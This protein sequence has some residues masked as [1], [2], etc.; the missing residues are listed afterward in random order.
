MQEWV[1]RPH[2]WHIA[3]LSWYWWRMTRVISISGICHQ[4]PPVSPTSPG[5]LLPTALITS[6]SLH[7]QVRSWWCGSDQNQD[8]GGRV[9]WGWGVEAR[10]QDDIKTKRDGWWWW[11]LVINTDRRSSDPGLAGP[12]RELVTLSSKANTTSLFLNIDHW[13][14]LSRLQFFTA[15]V[16]LLTGAANFLCNFSLLWKLRS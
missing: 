16:V 10:G 9:G 15:I 7:H 12:G 8:R 6:S 3:P 11:P 5:F 4:H 14:E 2:A 13:S 1:W